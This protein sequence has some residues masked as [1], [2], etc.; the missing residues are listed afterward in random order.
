MITSASAAASAM[1]STRSPAASALATDDEPSR[2]PTRTSIAGVLQ[3]QRVGVALG[4]VADDGDL[5]ALDDRPIGVGLVVHGCSHQLALPLTARIARLPIELRQRDPA[6]ALQLHDAIA[7]SSSSKSSSF[8]GWP[9]SETVTTSVPTARILPSKICTSSTTWPRVSAVAVHGGEQQLALDRSPGVELGDLH[10]LDELEQ[11]LGDLL[12]RRRVDVDDDRDAAE[13]LVLGRRDGQREDVEAPAGEQRRH[14]GE[15]AGA[16]LDEHG[17]DVVARSPTR[18]MALIA[19]TPASG[20][21]TG[22]GPGRRSTWPAG[23]IGNTFSP[24]STRKSTTTGRSSIALALSMAGWTS[25]GDSTRMP[26][27]PMA[28]AHFT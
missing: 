7:A 28:S 27:Q 21:A 2:R 19:R 5:A 18:L 10:H 3:V 23:T 1:G 6:G 9:S 15:H 11:L 13:P 25:S 16:V 8:S 17:Q 12:E 14:P 24:A 20:P 26:T 4:A 22:A